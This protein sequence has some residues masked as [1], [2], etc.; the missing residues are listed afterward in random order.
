LVS[1]CDGP[2]DGVLDVLHASQG[3]GFWTDHGIPGWWATD[4]G[5]F[6]ESLIGLTQGFLGAKVLTLEG[7]EELMAFLHFPSKYVE[8]A[9]AFEHG[10]KVLAKEFCFFV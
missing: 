1:A 8:M 5:W 7:L 10:G 2:H 9:S 6:D 3:G 4:E